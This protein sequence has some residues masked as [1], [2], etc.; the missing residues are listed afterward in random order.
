MKRLFLLRERARF[1][2]GN[3][4]ATA[5]EFAF[6]G[7][8]LILLLFGTIEG[9]RMLWTQNTLQYVVEQAARCAVVNQTTVP[10]GPCNTS[11]CGTTAQIQS[12]AAC[13]AYGQKLSTS[14]F[15]VA[16]PGCGANTTQVS[17]SLP[18][19]TAAPVKFSVTLTAQS[20]RPS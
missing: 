8:A 6:I 16:T 13:M 9:G 3:R 14:V 18:Y 11:P 15:S 17:A 19:T 2:M 20:C 10:N 4:G 1:R 5:V 12:Y 7:P